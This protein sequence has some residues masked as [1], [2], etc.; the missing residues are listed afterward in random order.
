[1]YA[2]PPVPSGPDL[3]RPCK[4][5]GEGSRRGQQARAAGEG[6]KARAAGE[7]SR[8]GQEGEGSR[9]GQQARAAG[10][11]RKAKNERIFSA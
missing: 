2:L 1:M 4:V 6:R 10:E 7:G 11:G 8:R 9:R 5:L 3:A